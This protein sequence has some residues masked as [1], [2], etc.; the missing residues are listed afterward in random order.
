MAK[1][2]KTKSGFRSGLEERVAKQLASLS[3]SYSYEEHKILYVIP[4]K[5]HWY[6]PDFVMHNGIIVETKGEFTPSDR[7]KHLLVQKQH[8]DLDIRFVFSNS[9]AKLSK[10]SSTTYAQWCD[11]HGF[12]YADKL[13]PIEWTR[14]HEKD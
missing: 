4:E 12:K 2:S 10:R 13:I 3:S 5:Q 6:T 1:M 11:K 9:K 7:V 8:P 14:E